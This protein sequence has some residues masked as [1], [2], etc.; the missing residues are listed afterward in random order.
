VGQIEDREGQGDADDPVAE[1]GDQRRAEYVAEV[2][3]RQDSESIPRPCRS[4]AQAGHRAARYLCRVVVCA[5]IS[6]G[7]S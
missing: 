5:L 7:A 3:K 1:A 6:E 4:V 2:V